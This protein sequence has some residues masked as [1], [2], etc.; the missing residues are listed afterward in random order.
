[1]K[2]RGFERTTSNWFH[3]WFQAGSTSSPSVAP[4]LTPPD[5]CALPHTTS[6]VGSSLKTA[7]PK[8]HEK[9]PSY[10]WNLFQ[11]SL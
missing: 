6:R 9:S 3:N 10:A 4:L 2:T 5:R 7:G 1:V 8:I 11:F